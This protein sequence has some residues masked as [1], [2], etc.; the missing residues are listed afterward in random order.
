[1]DESSEYYLFS[2]FVAFYEFGDNFGYIFEE[3]Y[4]FINFILILLRFG[5]I[6]ILHF[7]NFLLY[8][9]NAKIVEFIHFN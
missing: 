9:N 2:L 6:L 5:D 1:M 4:I 8:Y 3:E 7:I